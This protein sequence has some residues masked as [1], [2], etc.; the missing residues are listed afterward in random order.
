MTTN[1]QSDL[2]NS[3]YKSRKIILE[4]L[5]NQGYDTS[6]YEDFGINE[7]H[8]MTTNNQ[9][10]MLITRE[11]DNKKVYVRYNLK[12]TIRPQYLDDLIEDLFNLEAVLNK[13]DSLIIIGKDEMNDSIKSYLKEIYSVD[14]H[15]LII[16]SLARL[17]YN[18]LEHKLVPKH[19]ILNDK[20]QEDFKNKYNIS[21]VKQIPE[22][23]RFDPVSQAIGLKPGDICKILRE[24]KTAINGVYYRYCVNK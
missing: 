12:K 11:S 20:E 19:I 5:Y 13:N 7:V 4:Q 14:N 16:I 17:Q 2:F 21:D 23:S 3:I 18:V 22:I 10:D 9:L 8:I 24:S 1:N 15:N 6:S